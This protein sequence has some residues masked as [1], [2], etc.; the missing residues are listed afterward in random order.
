[1]G[2]G[3]E[4]AGSAEAGEG[5]GRARAGVPGE[6]ESGAAGGAAVAGAG[7]SGAGA[8][9][10]DA[11]LGGTPWTPQWP[12]VERRGPSQG[13]WAWQWAGPPSEGSESSESFCS[14]STPGMCQYVAA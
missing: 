7:E 11:E 3:G 10:P 1:M 2:G 9:G 8:K 4:G 12:H 6:R 14:S 5:D 13:W